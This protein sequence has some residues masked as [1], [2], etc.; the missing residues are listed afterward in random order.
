MLLTCFVTVLCISGS[1]IEGASV[2]DHAARA[3]GHML[4]LTDAAASQSDVHACV[5]AERTSDIRAQSASTEA[6]S[7]AIWC[8]RAAVLRFCSVLCCAVCFHGHMPVTCRSVVRWFRAGNVATMPG[9]C[10]CCAAAG[11]VGG[12][13]RAVTVDGCNCCD[14]ERSVGGRLRAPHAC[15]SRR[16]LCCSTGSGMPYLSRVVE[17]PVPRR[18]F[19]NLHARF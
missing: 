6:Q 11:A 13:G 4:A 10:G 2:L 9:T 5:T 19:L 12:A 16:M 1:G 14:S 8:R 17:H 18:S 3:S 7:P 15:H